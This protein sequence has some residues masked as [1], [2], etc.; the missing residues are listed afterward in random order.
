[1]NWFKDHVYVAS[2]LSLLIATIGLVIKNVRAP[3]GEVDWIQ[4]A[5]II[6]SLACVSVVLTPSFDATARSF[7]AMFA[8]FTM[9]YLLAV[10]KRR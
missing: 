2:W 5:A 7:G 3:A 1:M 9:G 10:W 6:A 4:A 8:T